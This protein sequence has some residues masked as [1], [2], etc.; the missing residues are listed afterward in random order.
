MW[1]C[2]SVSWCLVLCLV[3]VF[4]FCVVGFLGGFLFFV[5]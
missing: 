1:R 5:G 2:G 3:V 4:S